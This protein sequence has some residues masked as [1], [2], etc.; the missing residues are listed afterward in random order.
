M[1]EFLYNQRRKLK[2][3][4]KETAAP[5]ETSV[6]R[7]LFRDSC[8]ILLSLNK[9]TNILKTNL[10]KSLRQQLKKYAHTSKQ[11]LCQRQGNCPKILLQGRCFRSYI[12]FIQ[13][14]IP[15]TIRAF[16]LRGKIPLVAEIKKHNLV[17][18]NHQIKR[19]S[20]RKY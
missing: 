1:N 8:D 16:F 19:S 14:N 12:I 10:N 17:L 7:K 13:K 20:A 2:T 5:K 6:G 15:C 3:K 9:Y 11:S 4:T 18:S